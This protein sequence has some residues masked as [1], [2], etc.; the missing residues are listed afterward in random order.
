L[1]PGAIVR[2][3]PKI[4]IDIGIPLGPGLRSV[5]RI[6]NGLIRYQQNSLNN[7]VLNEMQIGITKGAVERDE[8]GRMVA[9][10]KTHGPSQSLQ[11]LNKRLGL[12]SFEMTSNHDKMSTNSQSPTTFMYDQTV[13]LPAGETLLDLEYMD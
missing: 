2:D 7:R 10:L 8:N 3:H 12:S 11:E 13:I 6:S 1:G 5:V 9:Y 4:E